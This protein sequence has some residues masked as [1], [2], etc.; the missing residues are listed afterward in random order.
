ME[1]LGFISFVQNVA[2]E[3]GG[4]FSVL[5]A[6]SVENVWARSTFQNDGKETGTIKI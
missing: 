4:F 5:I 3:L 2:E 1:N 6:Y